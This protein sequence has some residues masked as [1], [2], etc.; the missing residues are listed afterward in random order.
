MGFGISSHQTFSWACQSKES[1]QATNSLEPSQLLRAAPSLLLGLA[2]SFLSLWYAR[3][4]GGEPQEPC[5]GLRCLQRFGGKGK[6]KAGQTR[7]KRT[8]V[9][10]SCVLNIL[11]R[12]LPLLTAAAPG[13]DARRHRG[14][15]R[16]SSPRDGKLPSC[17]PGAS[18]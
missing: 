4:W 10:G 2:Q 11:G 7:L 5:R 12:P 9:R 8:L 14:F 1:V 15:L 6:W 18:L 17:K 3:P 13:R 16:S